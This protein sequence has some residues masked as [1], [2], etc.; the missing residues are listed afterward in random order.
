MDLQN[1]SHTNRKLHPPAPSTTNLSEG[2]GTY[3]KV[4]LKSPRH[5]CRLPESS[6]TCLP[7]MHADE[8][9]P[10][11]ADWTSTDSRERVGSVSLFRFEGFRTEGCINV[12]YAGL[13]VWPEKAR[14]LEHELGSEQL[15]CDF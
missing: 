9:N 4:C 8:S 11:I 5:S 13:G 1:V 7:A 14:H 15:Q 2:S 12:R 6:V 10:K 3:E